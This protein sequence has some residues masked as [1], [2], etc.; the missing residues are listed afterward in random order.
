MLWPLDMKVGSCNSLNLAVL[1]S[2]FSESGYVM[3][4]ESFRGSLVV[5][6]VDV[7]MRKEEALFPTR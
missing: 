3:D 2:S 1:K 6:E 7:D 4:F 5:Q